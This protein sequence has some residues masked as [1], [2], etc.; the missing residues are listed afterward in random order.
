M[1]WDFCCCELFALDLCSPVS[2]VHRADTNVTREMVFVFACRTRAQF[3]ARCSS[4]FFAHRADTQTTLV[5]WCWSELF[6]LGLAQCS[7]IMCLPT[8]LAAILNHLQSSLQNGDGRVTCAFLLLRGSHDLWKFQKNEISFSR[9]WEFVKTERGLLKF[10]NFV[11]FRALG[12]KLSAYKS[13]TAFPK[14]EEYFKKKLS[15]EIT[16]IAFPLSFDWYSALAISSRKGCTPLLDVQKSCVPY[17][18]F[19]WYNN[20]NNVHLSCAH[21]RPEHSHDT[22]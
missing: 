9:P 15:C 10:V 14:T 8:I 13:E 11:V 19:L 2:F 3:F 4:V 7:Q 18:A 6:T 16:K 22:Y 1:W 17:V 5:R 12:K 21:Q 20:N